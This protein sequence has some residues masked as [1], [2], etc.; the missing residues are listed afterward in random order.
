MMQ[1]E[2]EINRLGGLQ[3]VEDAFRPLNHAELN[4]IEKVLDRKLPDDYVYLVKRYGGCSFTNS[5]AFKPLQKEPAYKHPEA[6]GI[7]NGGQFCGSQ[8][9]EFYGKRADE[10][11]LA[12]KLN[13]YS[14]RM[15]AGFLPFADDGLGN[16]LCLCLQPDNYA[17]VYWWDHELEWDEEDYAEE[18]GLPMPAAAQYQNLYLVAQSVAGFFAALRIVSLA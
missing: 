1:I 10:F 11:T 14:R 12:D 9:A 8:V 16:Q 17:A 15:P 6:L 5:V 3:P 2:D 7:P 4:A 13:T 18:T